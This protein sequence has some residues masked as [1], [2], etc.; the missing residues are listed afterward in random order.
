MMNQKNKN[1]LSDIPKIAQIVGAAVTAFLVYLLLHGGSTLN[2][3]IAVPKPEVKIQT[4]TKTKTAL[5]PLML[6]AANA[7]NHFTVNGTVP[8][9]AIKLSIDNELRATFGEGHFTNNL[10]VNEQIKPAK[11]LD[12]LKGFFDF[13][14]L[15]GAELTANGDVLTL[16][17]TAISLK[18]DVTNFVGDGTTVKALDVNTN[19]N[20]ANTNA[21]SALDGLSVN[22]DT[23][24]I[25]NAM[26][27]QIINF[28][29]GSTQI[30]AVNQTVLK[31]A[32]LLLKGKSDGFEIAGHADNVGNEASNLTLSEARAKAVLGFLAKQQV[33]ANNMTA[34]G[35]GSAVPVASNDT[36]TGRLKNRRI[37]YKLAK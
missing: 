15:P 16:S 9:E 14:K 11:W 19:V 31:K 10:T 1:F 18:T 28:A 7:Q 37:E 17:G 5:S 36:E 24:S 25:L 21:L 23:Q 8:S 3:S 12:H 29:S 32:A 4:N 26:N 6:T 35:Y 34:K 27:M 22:S 13:F 20:T 33:P 2:H 30:P